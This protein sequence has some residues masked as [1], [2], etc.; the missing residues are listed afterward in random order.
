MERKNQI[1][2][3]SFLIGIS[4]ILSNCN[5]SIESKINSRT[6]I[7]LKK[8]TVSVKPDLI[9]N[10]LR[11]LD[12]TSLHNLTR[13]EVHIKEYIRAHPSVIFLNE[14]NTQ[15]L[16]ASQYEGDI[17]N[18]FSLFELGYLQDETSF[19]TIGIKTQIKDFVTES[20]LK[21]GISFNQ[22]IALKGN[23]YKESTEGE[24]KVISYT[25]ED[26]NNFLIKETGLPLYY[27]Q[28]FLKNDTVFRIV[29]GFEY[30]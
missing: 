24:I 3:N 27:I 15:Y 20:G 26:P 22:L 21:L 4:L 5:G 18:Y 2:V 17:A 23:G 10:G 25:I 30:P 29:F 7:D 14:E 16:I 12:E 13:K 28:V 6:K 9:V 1:L 11:L 8:D 19:D